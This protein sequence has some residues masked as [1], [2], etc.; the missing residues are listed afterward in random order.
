MGDELGTTVGDEVSGNPVEADDMLH[1]Q[2]GSLGGSWELGKGNEVNCLRKSVN[3]S[4][5]YSVALRRRKTSHKV[6]ADV[7]PGATRNRKGT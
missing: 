1:K 7:R 3:N 6:E 4:E 5:Y 2:L